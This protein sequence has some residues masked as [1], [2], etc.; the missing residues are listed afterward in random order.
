MGKT[1]E[2]KVRDPVVK[3]AK[4]LGIRHIRMHFGYGVAT[5]LP[6]DLFLITGGRPLFMEFKSPG[7]EPTVKQHLKINQLVEAG[8][9]AEWV[10]NIENGKAC[11]LK[12]LRDANRALK[13]KAR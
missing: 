7:K 5:G 2:S 12:H 9:D 10:N 6:D 4:G 13:K 8:Y 1:P 11:V 3:H